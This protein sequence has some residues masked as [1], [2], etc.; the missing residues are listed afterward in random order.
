MSDEKYCYPDSNVLI[1]KFGIRNFE[2]LHIKE[3]EIAVEATVKNTFFPINGDFDL[4]HLQSIHKSLFEEIY[5]W[6]GKIR[7]VDIA[8]SNLF[9]R[10]QFLDSYAKDIFDR[11][12]CDRFLIGMGREKA[13]IK[14]AE[15]IGDINA[16]HPFREGNG[17]TQRQF[18]SYLAQATG[19]K[20]DMRKTTPD[21]MMEASLKSFNMDFRGFEEIF[22][23]ILIPIS[24][25][26]QEQFIKNVSKIAYKEFQELKQHGHLP[27]RTKETLNTEKKQRMSMTEWKKAIQAKRCTDSINIAKENGMIKRM[28]DEREHL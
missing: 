16:L 10:V 18:I 14:L 15:Y 8:K 2:D 13:V 1:N 22:K 19:F 26:E 27:D 9:C 4:K 28:I 20:L 17:R 11:L 25:D 5:G 3:Y 6:A 23:E 21:K 24:L 12:K 7:T